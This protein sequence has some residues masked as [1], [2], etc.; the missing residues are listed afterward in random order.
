[1]IDKYT[2]RLAGVFTNQGSRFRATNFIR[3]L[4]NPMFVFGKLTPWNNEDIPPIPVP[5]ELKVLE[6][7]IYLRTTLIDI[8]DYEYCSE[9]SNYLD[10]FKDYHPS[11]FPTKSNEVAKVIIA[12][13]IPK[14]LI[15]SSFRAIGLVSDVDITPGTP[16]SQ[17]YRPQEIIN[18]GTLHWINYLSPTSLAIG[19]PHTVSII[20]NC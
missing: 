9:D 12:T 5:S 1:M 11:L 4:V 20:I 7:H 18:A 13:H 17:Y 3:S 19:G 14:N 10:E 16:Y 2:Y 8:L 15:T 6:P